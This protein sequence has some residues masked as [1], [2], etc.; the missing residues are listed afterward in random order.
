MSNSSTVTFP[1]HEDCP[2]CGHDTLFGGVQYSTEEARKPEAF[3][4]VEC[5]NR[6]CLWIDAG[7]RDPYDMIDG[8]SGETVDVE[9]KGPPGIKIELSNPTR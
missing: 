8:Y 3:M 5:E 4:Y 2:K 6:N 1:I 9:F 7:K